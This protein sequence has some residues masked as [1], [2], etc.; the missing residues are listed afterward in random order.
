[1]S[2]PGNFTSRVMAAISALPMEQRAEAIHAI[3]SDMLKDLSAGGI[4]EM[5]EEVRRQFDD[6]IPIIRSA[7]DLIDGQLALREIAGSAH[8]R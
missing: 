7:L 1:M 3:L 2:S 6:D 8:W 4:L 5:R